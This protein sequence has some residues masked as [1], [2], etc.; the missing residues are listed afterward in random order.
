MCVLP[1]TG[2]LLLPTVVDI[3]SPTFRRLGIGACGLAL[4]GLALQIPGCAGPKRPTV[5]P[6]LGQVLFQG[7]PTPGAFVAFHPLDPQG[8]DVPHP[9]AYADADGRFA[10]GTYGR[11]DGAPAGEYAVTVV[12]WAPVQSAKA[13]EGDAVAPT[14]RL[15]SRY[16]D[17][18]KS[19]LR[20][21]VREGN[22]ELTVQLAR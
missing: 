17:A 6:V 13:Q 9:T 10:L 5:H 4:L 2:P 11:H 8:K 7:R 3:L 21:S 15:P 12:W 16:G 20:A 19:G 22:N 14:N 18:K 1:D